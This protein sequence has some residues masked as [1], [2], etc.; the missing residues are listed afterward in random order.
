M[1]WGP[2]WPPDRTADPRGSTA[3]T[4]RSGLRS[5]RYSPTPVIVPPVPTPA[6]STSTRPSSARSISGPVVRRWISGLAGFENWSGRNVSGSRA[7]ARA[8]CTASAIPPSDSVMSTRAPYSRS[9]LSRS[10]L[11]PCGSV[12]TRSYPLAAH[13]NAS[14]IPVLPL[15]ASTILVRPGSILPS[16]SAA[17]IIATPMRSLTLPPGLNASSFANS[18]TPSAAP[19]VPSSICGSPT[20]GVLPTSSAMLIGIPVIGHTT[21]VPRRRPRPLGWPY[22]RRSA[23]SR[24][25]LHR[26]EASQAHLPAR[27]RAARAAGLEDRAFARARDCARG[28]PLDREF[29]AVARF[30]RHRV[31]VLARRRRAQVGPARGGH[32]RDRR[33][34]L[35]QFGG[36]DLFVF[37]VVVRGDQRGRRLRRTSELLGLSVLALALHRRERRD[38][39]RGEDADDQDH[40]QKLDQR[41]AA[42]VLSADRQPAKATCEAGLC[43]AAR[44]LRRR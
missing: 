4:R 36:R 40:D 42:L 19:A 24:R 16:A 31:F 6:T 12:S 13:T 1:R 28:A 17:S 30:R 10:R 44:V 32:D 34:V 22:M 26:G 3:T 25:A 21:I 29:V 35:V 23:A 11:I 20:S 5:R 15:V 41:E 2:A 37:A 33:L 8:A 9:R 14:A 38:R 43:A 7:I 39:D 27:A 18:S